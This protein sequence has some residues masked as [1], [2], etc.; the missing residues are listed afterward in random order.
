MFLFIR[1]PLRK[2]RTLS[3]LVPFPTDLFV[4]DDIAAWE[5][6]KFRVQN[7]SI[8]LGEITIRLCGTSQGRGIIGWKFANMTMPIGNL[9][10]VRFIESFN[11]ASVLNALP[12]VN[13]V[14]SLDHVVQTSISGDISIENY[15]QI[16]IDLKRRRVD[17]SKNKEFIF[18][19]PSSTIIEVIA[20]LRPYP[21]EKDNKLCGLAFTC[22]DLNHTHLA[23]SNSTKTPWPAIQPGRFITTLD[24]K[25]HNISVP[26][27]FMSP[28]LNALG[29][30]SRK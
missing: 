1:Q 27:A 23:L 17:T 4:G 12:H 18:F 24:I 22:N 26:I 8:A 10:G 5:S 14:Y 30:R 6:A 13:G 3:H 21:I 28:H 2:Q 25:Q 15:C 11:N 19:R 29:E 20:P 7:S 9:D 16:G